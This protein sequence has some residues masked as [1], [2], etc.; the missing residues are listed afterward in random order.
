MGSLHWLILVPY[1]FFAA[2]TTLL[3][4]SVLSRVLRVPAGANR[5]VMT[6]ILLSLVAV[7]APLLTGIAG[8]GDYEGKGFL[9]LA[10]AS[11]VLA[12]IDTLLAPRLSIPFDEELENL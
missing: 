5:L 8:I 2:L 10:V 1:Y 3:L 12:G 11:F 4:L 6:A 7:I 9:A